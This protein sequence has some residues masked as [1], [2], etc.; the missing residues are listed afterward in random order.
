MEK[1]TVGKSMIFR[2]LAMFSFIT[3][4]KDGQKCYDL[5]VLEIITI[6]QTTI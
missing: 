6:K 3:F 5:K 1:R 4:L 2:T